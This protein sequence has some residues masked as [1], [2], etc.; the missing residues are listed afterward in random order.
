MWPFDM[1]ALAACRVVNDDYC[2]CADGSDEVGTSAC[3]NGV[4]YCEN[5]SHRPERLYASRVD[6]GICDCCDGADEPEG[7]C[8]DTCREAGAA[9]REQMEKDLADYRTGL[10]TAATYKSQ[11]LRQRNEWEAALMNMAQEKEKLLALVATAEANLETAKAQKE[12]EDAAAAAAASSADEHADPDGIDEGDD[13]EYPGPLAFLSDIA[14][15]LGGVASLLSSYSK[16]PGAFPQPPSP[17]ARNG[18]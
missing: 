5:K 1:R 9:A 8:A 3:A 4:F 7:V 11:A 6:D 14:H 2:D 15:L 17:A 10:E 12:A 13:G 18:H 16:A